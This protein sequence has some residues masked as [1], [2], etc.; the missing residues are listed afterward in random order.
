MRSATKAWHRESNHL[1]KFVKSE[2]IISPGSKIPASR[3]FDLYTKWCDH[4]GKRALT[5]Q[6]FKARLQETHDITP[7][8]KS[9][10]CSWWRG[11]GLRG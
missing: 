2:L 9:K 3:L 1:N 6:D 7:T 11:V 8:R 4:H 10:G 5:V